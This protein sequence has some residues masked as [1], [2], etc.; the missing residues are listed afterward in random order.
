LAP[1]ARFGSRRDAS[2]SLQA[3][4]NLRRAHIVTRALR[5]Q[6]ANRKKTTPPRVRTRMRRRCSR[7]CPAVLVLTWRGPRFQSQGGGATSPGARGSP[8]GAAAD[9]DDFELQLPEQG[10][11]PPAPEAAAQ[12]SVAQPQQRKPLPPL[13]PLSPG[14]RERFLK[15]RGVRCVLKCPH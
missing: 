12:P 13:P 2:H 11:P 4:R 3:H 1:A 6:V 10:P 7:F 9:D 8:G 5:A 15:V 14:A